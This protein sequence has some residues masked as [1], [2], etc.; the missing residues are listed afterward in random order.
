[1]PH[2]YEYLNARSFINRNNHDE[3]DYSLYLIDCPP[4]IINSYSLVKNVVKKVQ[5]FR[6]Y[7]DVEIIQKL[8]DRSAL[9]FQTQVPNITNIEV[10]VALS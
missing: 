3:M 6:T 4:Q 9:F 7:S 5:E 10:P 2:I 8:T 1:M